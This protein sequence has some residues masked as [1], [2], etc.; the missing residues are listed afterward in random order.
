MVEQIV[1]IPQA[2]PAG[3]VMFWPQPYC[4]ELYTRIVAGC[5]LEDWV[6]A[7]DHLRPFAGAFALLRDMHAR[8]V[9]AVEE[10][11]QGRQSPAL[12]R[13]DFPQRGL[14]VFPPPDKVAYIEKAGYSHVFLKWDT[15]LGP[16]SRDVRMHQLAALLSSGP[17]PDGKMWVRMQ[18]LTSCTVERLRQT[19]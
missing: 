6:T 1:R 11:A 13:E 7:N 18:K 14:P 9:S 3:R 5:D 17:A 15:P 16:K 2:P 10:W 4:A 12:R 19:S 8:A